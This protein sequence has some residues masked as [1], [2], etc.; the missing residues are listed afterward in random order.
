MKGTALDRVICSIHCR[1]GRLMELLVAAKYETR[2][3]IIRNNIDISCFTDEY[4]EYEKILKLL[5]DNKKEI[6]N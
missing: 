3:M 4:D 2:D 6:Y 1:Q 5:E